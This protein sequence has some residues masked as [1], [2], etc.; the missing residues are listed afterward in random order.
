ML[1]RKSNVRL[2]SMAASMVATSRQ[3]QFK[4]A[5]N[6][7]VVYMHYMQASKEKKQ[8]QTKKNEA[9]TS[10]GLTLKGAMDLTNG[11]AQWQS[12]IHTHHCQMAELRN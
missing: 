9:I 5:L 3:K 1:L 6:S 4:E 2:F 10:L 12:F 11:Q 7:D 8:R